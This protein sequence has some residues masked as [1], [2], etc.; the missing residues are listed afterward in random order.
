MVPKC[1]RLQNNFNEH[2]FDG[3]FSDTEE[4]YTICFQKVASRFGKNFDFSLK[5]KIMGQQSREFAASIIEGL[6]LPITVDE[7]LNETREIFK[8]LFPQCK[9]LPGKN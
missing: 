2:I 1:F 5:C 6:E 3:L 4:L 9:I 7:F 8:N